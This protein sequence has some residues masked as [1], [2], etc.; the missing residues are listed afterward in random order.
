M[1]INI[2]LII[3]N[4]FGKEKLGKLYDDDFSERKFVEKPITCRF[5]KDFELFLRAESFY[6]KCIILTLEIIWSLY[7]KNELKIEERI[8]SFYRHV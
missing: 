2:Q 3:Y 8:V 5:K 7:V 1:A 6:R 4:F